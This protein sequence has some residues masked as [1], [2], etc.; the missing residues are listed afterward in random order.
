MDLQGNDVTL[1][2]YIRQLHCFKA[3]EYLVIKSL[4]EQTD[5]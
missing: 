1:Q 5:G 4:N 3:D 2:M